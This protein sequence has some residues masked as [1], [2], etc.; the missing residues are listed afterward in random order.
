MINEHFSL[1]RE[2]L[3]QKLL[4]VE[5]D[6]IR[7]FS[8]SC[9]IPK[10]AVAVP[11]FKS[12]HSDKISCNAKLNHFLKKPLID[13]VQPYSKQYYRKTIIREEC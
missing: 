12:G 6:L 4:T 11:R 13:I 10:E 1:R 3:I 9:G 8:R 2:V 5:M 7:T